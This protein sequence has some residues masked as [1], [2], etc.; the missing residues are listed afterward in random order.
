MVGDN[1]GIFTM[2]TNLYGTTALVAVGVIAGGLAADEASA[3][4][5]L[6]LGICYFYRNEIG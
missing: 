4:R 6:N 2:R 5:C 3:A 1:G